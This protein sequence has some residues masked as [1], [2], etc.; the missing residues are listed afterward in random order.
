MAID[1]PWGDERKKKFVTNVGLITSRG[2]NGDDIMAAEWTHQISYYP[3]IIA[4]CIGN[5]NQEGKIKASME[6]IKQSGEFGV[7]LAA[8]DQSVIASVAGNN[9]G[10]KVDKIAALKDLGYKFTPAKH[11][12]VLMVDGASMQ[13]ECKVINTHVFGSH[14]MFIGEILESTLGKKDSLIYYQNSYW[15]TPQQTQKISDEDKKLIS[16]VVAEHTKNSEL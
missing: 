12:K 6:N 14:T 1:L 9:T 3:G 11:I 16:D 8:T 2:E 13:A 7:N 5:Q 15:Y 4:V 10:K